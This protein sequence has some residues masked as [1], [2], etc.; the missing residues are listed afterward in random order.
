[1]SH[2][3]RAKRGSLAFNLRLRRKSGPE[4]MRKPGA[5]KSIEIGL[6]IRLHEILRN[7]VSMAH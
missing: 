4:V 1:M 7:G 3:A 6:I 5:G 2:T